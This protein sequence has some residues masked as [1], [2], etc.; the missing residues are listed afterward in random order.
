MYGI[1]AVYFAISL[2]LLIPIIN[3]CSK[4]LFCC[5][6]IISITVLYLMYLSIKIIFLISLLIPIHVHYYWDWDDNLCPEL[7]D[8]TLF[9]L[10]FNYIMLVATIVYSI[11]FGI[12]TC[13][14]YDRYINVYDYIY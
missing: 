4:K 8:L 5:D 12:V 3:M 9:W 14:G 11:F 10:I 6:G 1:V 2:I 13:C 7:K